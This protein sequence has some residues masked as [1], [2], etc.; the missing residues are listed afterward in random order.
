MKS[1]L[2]KQIIRRFPDT[3]V[4]IGKLTVTIR[5]RDIADSISALDDLL[6]RF[7]F[8]LIHKAPLG[9]GL[10]SHALIKA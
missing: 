3:L 10:P 4:E 1:Y 5:F 7:F 2:A 8:E 6:D 9:Y